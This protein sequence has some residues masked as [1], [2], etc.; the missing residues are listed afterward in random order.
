M[1][2]SLEDKIKILPK[3]RQQKIQQQTNDLIA[4]KISLRDI[5]KALKQNQEDLDNI[6]SIAMR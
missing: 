2:R 4:E 1:P 3:R 5:R 6:R